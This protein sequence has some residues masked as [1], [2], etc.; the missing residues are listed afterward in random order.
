MPTPPR[1][2]VEKIAGVTIRGSPG[3]A[4]D[5]RSPNARDGQRNATVWEMMRDV[6]RAA[7]LVEHGHPL[8]VDDV[9]L[10]G[11]GPEEVRVRL[12]FAGVN[13]IDRYNAEGRAAA[14][15]P[16]PR[17]LGGEASGLL[18]GRPVVVVGAGLGSTRDGVFA[19]EAVVP[20]GAVVPVP[21]AVSL[22]EAGAMGVA[23]LTSWN[24]VSLAGV[25]PDDRV[26][27][28][29][30]SGGVGS[31]IVSLVHSLG[32]TVWGQCRSLR[33][34]AAV[35]A[36]GADEVVV[37]GAEDL[38]ESVRGLSPTVVTD[39]LGGAFTGAAL[40]VLAADGRLV[41]YGTSAGSEATLQLQ[42]VYRSGQRILGYA[43]LRL[44]DDTRRQDLGEA[45]AALADGRLRI[46]IGR[47]FP[48]EQVNDAFA[49][50][51]DGSVDGKIL[52]ELAPP[53]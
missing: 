5:G 14:D 39:P 12:A 8:R 43:G 9:Q 35:R 31:T 47:I 10:P 19:T 20:L 23:G 53:G 41:L 15:G 25:G 17:T 46:R 34:A 26:L 50:A 1:E 18:D 6:T 36:Q 40:S 37:G 45:L 16:V 32:A 49:A 42:P 33:K 22:E 11:P 13:P 3:T 2:G 51:G 52:L 38:A 29:G 27:V 21:G 44:S 28:L 7:R 30:A 4:Q 24:V 48:L